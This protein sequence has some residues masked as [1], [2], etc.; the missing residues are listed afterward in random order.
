MDV[1]LVFALVASVVVAVLVV[2]GLGA[3]AY[4]SGD[5]ICGFDR[6]IGLG[7]L[8]QSWVLRVFFSFFSV[9]V[10]INGRWG[11][12]LRLLPGLIT[13]NPPCTKVTLTQSLGS[14]IPLAL[15]NTCVLIRGDL[16]QRL[17]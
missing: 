16:F 15:M 11:C 1:D 7:V 14:Y 10:V 2:L 12:C 4:G 3:A 8:F 5:N 17:Q 9:V 6:G 13:L